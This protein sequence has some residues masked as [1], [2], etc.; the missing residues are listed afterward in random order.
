MKERKTREL[1][2]KEFSQI[3]SDRLIIPE[4]NRWDIAVITYENKTP[5]FKA[6]IELKIFLRSKCEAKTTF[7]YSPVHE[8]IRNQYN[9]IPVG[10]I[11][12]YGNA[13]FHHHKIFYQK[14]H[15]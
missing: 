4:A 6:G 8:R 7:L 2:I 3:A 1:L 15:P 12:K 10:T 11:I 14:T 5:V 9:S 13:F